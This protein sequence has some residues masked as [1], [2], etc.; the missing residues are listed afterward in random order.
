MQRFLY[1]S[2]SY[3]SNNFKKCFN[4]IKFI[5]YYYVSLKSG[6]NVLSLILVYNK[7][8]GKIVK[9]LKPNVTSQN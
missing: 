4:I 5:I 6:S 2:I 7:N 8:Q 3:L 9:T 1:F